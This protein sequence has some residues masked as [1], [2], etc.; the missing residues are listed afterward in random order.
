MNVTRSQL[1]FLTGSTIHRK[2]SIAIITHSTG[3]VSL[4]VATATVLFALHYRQEPERTGSD[5]YLPIR[6]LTPIEA[7]AIF[8][9]SSKRKPNSSESVVITDITDNNITILTRNYVI[10]VNSPNQKI[11]ESYAGVTIQG[12]SFRVVSNSWENYV[13]EY[14][15]DRLALEDILGHQ[16][17]E[18]KISDFNKN[19]FNADKISF[20]SK[21]IR[22][23]VLSEIAVIS[24]LLF[25]ITQIFTRVHFLLWLHAIPVIDLKFSR[26]C[27]YTPEIFREG[28]S[29]DYRKAYFFSS[30]RPVAH[31][32]FSSMCS[33]L[34]WQL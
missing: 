4:I 22:L 29:H 34:P 16:L 30:N 18:T 27:L 14:E 8:T 9:A 6:T 21:N 26:L 32:L 1:L 7:A 19:R 24:T 17:S 31:A 20:S 12:K 10:P 3:D 11:P 25:L 23:Y 33:S 13:C 2:H 15:V 5:A 28:L